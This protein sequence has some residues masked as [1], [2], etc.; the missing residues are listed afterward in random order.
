MRHNSEKRGDKYPRAPS[1]AEWDA[2]TP[3]EQAR[4]VAALPNVVT[5]AELSPPEG[6]QHF[7]PKVRALDTLKGHFGREGR[8]VYLASELP[9]Y[10][11]DERRFAPDLLVVLDAEP[12]ERGKWMVSAEGKG[13]D[14][15][16]EVH[17]GGRRKKDAEKN[18][19]R[20][21]RLR[22]P[23]YFIYDGGKQRLWG[24][25]LAAPGARE[26]VP[27]QSV[28]G[29]FPS[30]R[31]GLELQVEGDR[32]RFYENNVQLPESAELIDQ[33]RK[34]ADGLKRRATSRARSLKKEARL[35]EVTEQRLAQEQ[36]LREEERRLREEEQRLR[37]DVQQQLKKAQAELARLKSQRA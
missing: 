13:L 17:V 26:Y 21:S 27:I 30:E 33:L 15:V 29:R 6:D 12:H 11:P 23:E 34:L 28:D 31:L 35:R 7:L 25:R 36:R 14:F 19:A 16:L 4:V 24:Y 1:Q 37:E 5:D 22:I 32:L 10:Y 18:V 8:R 20:Y 2:L 3:E 9:V